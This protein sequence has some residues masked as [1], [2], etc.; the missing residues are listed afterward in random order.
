M[1]TYRTFRQLAELDAIRRADTLRQLPGSLPHDD[2][3]PTGAV[4][5][6]GLV[7]AIVAVAVIVAVF[8]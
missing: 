1:N 8:V 4:I 5:V 3:A 6:W 7:C 2:D